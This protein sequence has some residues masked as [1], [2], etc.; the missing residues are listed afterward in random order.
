MKIIKI[1]F[2]HIKKMFSTDPGWKALSL[3]LSVFIW[4]VVMNI[5][6]PYI[7]VTIKNIPVSIENEE[8]LVKQGKISDIDSGKTVTVK[9]TAPKSVADKLNAD[10]FKAS[11]DFREM[12]MVYAVPINVSLDKGSGFSAS[13]V[14]IDSKNPEVMTMT[15]EN[16]VS[17]IFSVDV[18]TTGTP[19]DGYYVSDTTTKPNIVTIT[20]SEKQISG[21]KDVV[22]T[23]DVTDV[24]SS[25]EV[26]AVPQ[27]YDE[28]GY[29][30]DDA[31]ISM[32]VDSVKTD[33]TVLPTKKIM[34]LV[35]VE[36]NPAFGYRCTGEQHVPSTVTIAGMRDDLDDIFSV[37]VPFNISMQTAD[38]E[39]TI[40]IQD[41]LN[42]N[43]GDKYILVD[44]KK[45]VTVKASIEKLPSKEIKIK[46]ADIEARNL[47]DGLKLSFDSG[48][49][50]TVN[51]YADEEILNKLTS[52]NLKLYVDASEIGKGSYYLEIKS[53]S[54]LDVT[55]G[56]STVA[57]HIE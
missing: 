18:R 41:Y 45:T 6:D 48:S 51:V 40:N 29:I 31:S 15:L 22:V 47:S 1:I 32:D 44:D 12:S 37:T 14:S 30:I 25:Y 35:S 23:L 5:D 53:D 55:L 46:T 43:Y 50:I 10:D 13:D 49:S 19:A 56:I 16:L 8:L 57:V 27:I 54:Q 36:G 4:L 17:E 9:V 38:V 3:I 21:I 28:N 24:S 2:H 39:S 52:K 42:T 20:G 11:A 33:I 7:T 34:L 26:S